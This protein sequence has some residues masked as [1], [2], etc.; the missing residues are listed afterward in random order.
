MAT[1]SVPQK[2]AGC[3]NILP[4]RGE[5]LRCEICKGSYDLEC[6][7]VSAKSYNLMER[8]QTWKCPECVSK[9]P[10]VG[11]LN[12]PV[13]TSSP[14]D[15]V[16][17]PVS[18]SPPSPKAV[19]DKDVTVRSEGVE[20]NSPAFTI[21]TTTADHLQSSIPTEMQLFWDE[22]K[23][24]RIEMS[25][26]RITMDALTYSI[27]SQNLRINALETRI[28]TL[29]KGL[30]DDRQDKIPES[31]K[32]IDLEATIDQLKIEL[33]E[34][35]QEQLA[36]DIEIASLPETVSENPSHVV[37]VIARKLGVELEDK[38]IVRAE[39]VGPP[40]AAGEGAAPRPRPLS[41]RLARRCTRDALL[42]AARVRR[43]FT[44][45]GMGLTGAAKLFYINE[46]LTKHNRQLFYETRELA[47]RLEW[48]YVWTRDGKIY[49][50]Q[51]HG[52]AR[53]RLRTGSD[54]M[55]V[56]GVDSVSTKDN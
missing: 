50:R 53:H 21:G 22:I 52:K 54:F 31:A 26:L 46:R 17:E 44:T 56:F 16:Q 51:E 47:K 11:N 14:G 32:V 7:N 55:K 24:F 43:R 1:K 12:T 15:I 35:D 48:K 23:A 13:R 42:S 3:R 20:N 10:K 4:R 49:A 18:T 5:H 30:S 38:D 27:N 45:E 8:K 19:G 39:R 25:K 34:R 36:N 6:A 28:D 33:L 40:R 29:E 41:V 2:C 37:L 9:R